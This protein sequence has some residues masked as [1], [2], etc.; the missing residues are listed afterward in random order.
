MLYLCLALYLCLY[1]Q[2]FCLRLLCL[3]LRLL[4]LCLCLAYLLF[5]TVLL[6]MLMSSTL[7]S[8]SAISVF[9]PEL[10]ALLSTSAIPMIVCFSMLC[11][12]WDVY[13]LICV[14]FACSC[15]LLCLCLSAMPIPECCAC[16]WV[17]CSLVCFY[18]CYACACT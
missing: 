3:G 9:V 11:F 14:C 6:P 4:C 16:A 1:G 17:F 8:L 13:F 5:Y 2:F 10:S 18:V 12:A 7:L 15:L